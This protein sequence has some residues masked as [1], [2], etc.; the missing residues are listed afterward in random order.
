MRLRRPARLILV[1]T[2][3]GLATAGAAAAQVPGYQGGTISLSTPPSTSLLRSGLLDFSRFD[4][5]H[6]VSFGYSSGTGGSRSGGL[7]LTRL[8]YR[9][10][11]PLRV[12]VDVG[13]TLD[14]SGQGAFLSEK[15]FFL[16]GFNLDY[17]PSKHFLVHVS[18]VNLPPNAAT[19]LGYRQGLSPTWGSP[20]GLDR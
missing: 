4:L 14:P 18:Y 8:G 10:S 16:K 11:D 7:W 12:S 2:A 5:S 6:S 1:G 9:V 13:A 3:L 17:R 15:S 19:A 20:L